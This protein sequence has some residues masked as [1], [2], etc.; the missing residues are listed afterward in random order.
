MN[1]ISGRI[2]T[3]FCSVCCA[4]FIVSCGQGC[5][6]VSTSVSDTQTAI[7]K[8]LS[9]EEKYSFLFE[10]GAPP[11]PDTPAEFLPRLPDIVVAPDLYQKKATFFTRLPFGGLTLSGEGEELGDY[12]CAINEKNY[13]VLLEEMGSVLVVISPEGKY[14]YEMPSRE[15][16]VFVRDSKGNIMGVSDD[17]PDQDI[18]LG[19]V[20]PIVFISD[21]VCVFQIGYFQITPPKPD[22]EGRFQDWGFA[23]TVV[24]VNIYTRKIVSERSFSQEILKLIQELQ[25]AGTPEGID[26]LER[27]FPDW[28]PEKLKRKLESGEAEYPPMKWRTGNISLADV[29]DPVA[30]RGYA[31]IATRKLGETIPFS[32]VVQ[33]LFS[34]RHVF[35]HERDTNGNQKYRNE[36]PFMSTL[37][38]ES[39]QDGQRY[40]LS[41]LTST[42]YGQTID[43]RVFLPKV[44]DT[45]IGFSKIGDEI[46]M[47]EKYDPPS[48]SSELWLDDDE[49][50]PNKNLGDLIEVMASPSGRVV[51]LYRTPRGIE[52]FK[53]ERPKKVER[54]RSR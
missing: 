28:H 46:V 33:P 34:N 37:F 47:V 20:G 45:V 36:Y 5:N 38:M 26:E 18:F 54:R 19:I 23:E 21:S 8:E 1:K 53:A 14:L 52:I 3:I 35:L 4:F 50:I 41:L 30:G 2:I 7:R 42:V 11:L 44:L 43:G 27:H 32:M 16:T 24:A 12:S 22:N 48:F 9:P 31:A 49:K 40:P 15:S 51:W 17:N 13:I 10:K 29:V 6:N 39:K 25:P